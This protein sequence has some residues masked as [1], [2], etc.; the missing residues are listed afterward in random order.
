M[1]LLFKMFDGH[2]TPTIPQHT[3]RAN[4]FLPFYSS[5]TGDMIFI[6]NIVVFL[7]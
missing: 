4:I 5:I 6:N 7:L 1:E 3:R 2:L